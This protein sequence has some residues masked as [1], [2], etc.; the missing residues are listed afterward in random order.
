MTLRASALPAE[1]WPAFARTFDGDG[2]ISSRRRRLGG[3]ATM[4][5]VL[6]PEPDA[7]AAACARVRMPGK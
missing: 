7:A 6:E 5:V 1:D 2:G 4:E 3:G